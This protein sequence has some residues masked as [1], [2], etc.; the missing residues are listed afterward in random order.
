AELR[1]LEQDG[2]A[3]D[4]IGARLELEQDPA[5]VLERGLARAPLEPAAREHTLHAR[6][7]GD[8]GTTRVRFGLEVVERVAD[9]SCQLLRDGLLW[10]GREGAR[11]PPAAHE[12]KP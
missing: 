3:L 6:I 5:Q 2:E 12:D 7:G 4:G 9:R 8:H 10:E 1:L 11:R